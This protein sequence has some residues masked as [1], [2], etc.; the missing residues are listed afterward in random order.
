PQTTSTS[1][2]RPASALS[3]AA[4]G[5]RASGSRGKTARTGP[6]FLCTDGLAATERGSDQPVGQRVRDAVQPA[7]ALA[8]DGL[9]AP[10]LRFEAALDLLLGPAQSLVR[11][12]EL[13]RG[14]EA[15]VIDDELGSE[16]ESAIARVAINVP[17]RA[18][19]LGEDREIDAHGDLREFGAQHRQAALEAR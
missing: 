11:P 18:G 13:F 10:A 14:A 4:E 7:P 5:C 12:G 15:L 2:P 9:R 17:Q 3:S 19:V 8:G 1:R 16:S 6:G